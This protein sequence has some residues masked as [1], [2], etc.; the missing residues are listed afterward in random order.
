MPPYWERQTNYHNSHAGYA[1][2]NWQVESV[3]RCS[4]ILCG[5]WG[6]ALF[7]L[8]TCPRALFMAERETRCSVLP[9]FLSL[10]VSSTAIPPP[11][12]WLCTSVR[13]ITNPMNLKTI[14]GH[15][16]DIGHYH[17]GIIIL[18][19]GQ[20]RALVNYQKYQSNQWKVGLIY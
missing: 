20:S 6:V 3:E 17:Q 15:F 14:H 8:V 7:L 18:W 1:D 5:V 13:H 2:N 16:R 9:S 11:S 4:D 19:R 10:L 12:W